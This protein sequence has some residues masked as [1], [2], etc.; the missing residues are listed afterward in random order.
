MTRRFSVLVFCCLILVVLAT[1]PATAAKAKNPP[2]D[3]APTKVVNPD[4]PRQPPEPI[5]C[6]SIC[7]SGS[8]CD[9]CRILG[10][11]STTCGQ[12]AGRP[13]ND[14]DGDG[15]VDT[16]D[17]CRCQANANQANCDGDA[18]GDACDAQDNSWAQIAVGTQACKVDED[19]GF[20]KITLEFYYRNVYRSACTGQTCYKKYLNGSVQCN[21]WDDTFECCKSK[22][23]PFTDCGGAWGY[24]N[25]GVPRCT[26]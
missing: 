20:P 9:V 18:Y 17:N 1:A 8:P 4:D 5:F 24:D 25:C 16:N 19:R 22:R 21:Y 26:F 6:A 12:Y 11:A 3:T 13:A 15:V 14:L 7:S 10:G 2:S 23:I